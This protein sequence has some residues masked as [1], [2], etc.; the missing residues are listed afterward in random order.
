MIWAA[1]ALM[2]AVAAA[3][4]LAPLQRRSGEA[5][6]RTAYDREIYRDQLAEVERDAQRGLIGETEAAAARTEIG[7]RLLASADRPETPRKRFESIRTVIALAIAAPAAA[8][9]LY[10]TLGAPQ[11]ATRIA[12]APPS[13]LS[14]LAAQLAEKVQERPDDPRGW[15]LLGRTLRTL[16]RFEEAANALGRAAALAPNDAGLAAEHG[17]MLSFAADGRIT[18]ESRDAFA[19]ALRIDPRE[20]RARYYLGLADAQD[21]NARGALERWLA[22]EADSPPDAPWRA[23]LA[24][25]I[26]QLQSELG[27]TAEN[28]GEVIRGM[29]EGLARRLQDQPDDADGWLRLARAYMV[30]GETDKARAALARLEKLRPG[31]ADAKALAAE[32]AHRQP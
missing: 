29:V 24:A 9:A 2:T 26:T 12:S 4:L 15:M 10:L 13:D 3:L 16:E 6:P 7:R 14:S 28:R 20:P 18:P 11:L 21:G 31:D 22:L 30:L 5:A 19:T 25:R 1:L 32:L 17:E 27:I 23:M 8:L